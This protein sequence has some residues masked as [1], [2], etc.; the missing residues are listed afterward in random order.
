MKKPTG[1][2]HFVFWP[3]DK[4]PYFLGSYARWDKT[5][6]SYW[7]PAYQ[8]WKDKPSMTFGIEAGV[9]LHAE[10]SKVQ[11]DYERAVDLL[12]AGAVARLNARIEAATLTPCKL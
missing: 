10:I 5:K 9:A 7:V 12:R 8:M 2:T 6:L 1:M 4:F 3:Y 11:N